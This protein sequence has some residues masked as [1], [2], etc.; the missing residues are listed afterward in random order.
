ML[1]VWLALVL[2]AGAA[3]AQVKAFTGARLYDGTGASLVPNATI[4]VEAGRVKAVDPAGKVQVPA[5]AQRIDVSGKTIVPGMINAHGHVADTQGL[6]TGAQFYTEENLL[7]QLGLYARYGVTTVFSLGGD[8]VAGFKLRNEQETPALNRARVY[9]AGE[10]ITGKTPEEARAQVDRVAATKPNMIKIR[11]DDNLGANPKMPPE[12]YRA[13]IDQ[14]RKHNL[15]VAAHLF[16]LED[17]RGLLE[18]GVGLVAHSIRDKEVDAETIGLLKKRGVCVVP[19]LTR[20][21][22]TF[23]YESKPAFFSDAFFLREADSAVLQQLQEPKRMEA[24]KASTSAQRYKTALEVAS[25]NLKKLVDSGVK[26]AMG[27]D[28]G[29]PARF[30]GYFEHMELELM[31]KAGMTPAQIMKSATGDAAECMQA[32]G[33]I[34]TLQ[35]GAWADFVVLDRNPLEDVKNMRTIQSVWIAGNQVP[36]GSAARSASAP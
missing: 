20:E 19:T 6:R 35:P 33:K 24:M 10:I 4:V 8:G 23:V 30:Q 1:R 31:A 3:H 9:V 26:I 2:S 12:V 22:S 21:V 29:P 27:T 15:S 25:R 11:V 36:R 7:R 28:T 13:V 14:A 17:A 18:S 16:Y 32:A 5:G 34:G